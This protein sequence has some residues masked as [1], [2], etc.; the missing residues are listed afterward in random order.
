MGSTLDNVVRATIKTHDDIILAGHGRVTPTRIAYIA[1]SNDFGQTWTTPWYESIANAEWP[2]GFGISTD[3]EHLYYFGRMSDML[4]SWYKTSDDSSGNVVAHSYPAWRYD[5]YLEGVTKI[6]GYYYAGMTPDVN[7]SISGLDIGCSSDGI[8]W[9]TAMEWHNDRVYRE[10]WWPWTQFKYHSG[11]DTL[12]AYNWQ[13]NVDH[14]TKSAIVYNPTPRTNPTNWIDWTFDTEYF[15]G[16]RPYQVFSLMLNEN[17]GQPQSF[18][19]RADV[20]GEGVPQRQ[21]VFGLLDNGTYDVWHQSTQY[22]IVAEWDHRNNTILRP[23]VR[24]MYCLAWHSGGKYMAQES[25][26]TQNFNGYDIKMLELL[27]TP[28][29]TTDVY[30]VPLWGYYTPE[31]GR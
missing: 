9:S 17:T 29:P 14:T 31:E 27:T 2:L 18:C 1:R 15:S 16:L 8:N 25:E 6:G 24:K 7:G 3:D 26:A 10:Y 21:C 13:Y 20:A 4:Y 5:T 11:T 22:T 19:A 23:E 30:P 28:V 12:W